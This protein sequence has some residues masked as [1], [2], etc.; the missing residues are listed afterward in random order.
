M[1]QKKETGTQLS[2]EHQQQ[3]QDLFS[4]YHQ[5]AERL[6]NSTDQAQIEAIL[7]N[8]TLLPMPAQLALIKT[9]AREHTTD[10]ADVLTAIHTLGIHKDTR[11][12]ARRGLIQLEAT[13]TYSRWKPP[14]VQ[15]PAIQLQHNE[16]PRFWQGLV[17]Q[18][19]DQGEI[20]LILCWEQGYDYNDVRVMMFTLHYWHA[21]ITDVMVETLSKRRLDQFIDQARAKLPDDVT[22][23]DCTLAEGKRLIEEALSVNQ[24][25][26]STPDKSYR[27]QLPLI[28]KL[29]LQAPDLDEDRGHTFINPE[30]EEQEVIVNFLGAWS[31]GDYGLAY[32]LL[33]RDSSLHDG[34]SRDA[35]MAHRRQWYQE[36]HPTRVK[37]G[38]VHE[39]EKGQSALW[40]PSS[41]NLR[42]P[43]LKNI[44]VGWSLELSDTPLSGTLKEMPMATAVNKETGRHWFWTTY[45]L[46]HEDGVW[47]IQHII[48]EGLA[49]QGLS[50][51]ELQS[52]IK[53]YQ[54]IV[55]ELAKQRQTSNAEKAL[56]DVSRHLL[57]MVYF[58]DVL[59]TLL[60][61]DY[62]IHLEAYA[63]VHLL[64]DLEHVIVYL[65]FMVQRFP[66]QRASSLHQLSLSLLSLTHQYDRQKMPERIEH[67]LK[68]AE[69]TVQQSII[70]N[71][72]AAG[73]M[74]YGELLM[75][76]GIFDKAEAE[77]LIALEKKPASNIE[78]VIEA[79]LG[80]I[81]MQH[82][83]PS[84]AITHYKRVAEISPQHPSIWF[85][86]GLAH[87]HLGELEDAVQCYQQAIQANPHDERASRELAGIYRKGGQL[88]QARAIIEQAVQLDPESAYL[89]AMLASILLEQGDHRAAQKELK[90]AEQI[91]PE[92]E[93]VQMMRQYIPSSKRK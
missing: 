66:E 28:N 19:R 3:I 55:E 34:L 23:V 13:K 52:R 62:Q 82:E 64:E 78:T 65:D 87:R 18:C 79:G 59:L 81:A 72:D 43:S 45:T 76:K 68:R 2:Q 67:L 54:H 91:D 1:A 88:D 90:A 38:F 77:L 21:G 71:D 51:L 37:L 14:I 47:R 33:T 20:Q 89:H 8:I 75:H 80:N 73:H 22:L 4:Q 27:H 44:E 41:A 29:I 15:A 26:G 70:I 85:N 86:L 61:L 17:T 9:L 48:D 32:D 39:R 25:H 6:H 53:E 46:V 50:T 11:K 16:S 58:Y 57:Q 63:H 31:F 56:E 84:E 92:L 60:P 10:A 40:L 69:E 74:I 49:L 12:E 93:I 5:I 24:W 35:W 30:L 36:A 7:T 83:Q 42:P